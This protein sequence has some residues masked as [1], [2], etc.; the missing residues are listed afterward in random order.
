MDRLRPRE[1]KVVPGFT[2]AEIERMDKLYKESGNQSLDREFYRRVARNFNSSKGRAGKPLVKW[3]E[4]ESWFQKR[5]RDCL[6]RDASSPNPPKKLSVSPEVCPAKKAHSDS[7]IDKDASIDG[8]NVP[9]LSELEFEA[10]SS[11]DGAW[12]DVDTF[13]GHRCLG[14]GETEVHVRYI[15]FGSEEDE[16]VNVKKNVRE[17]SIALEHWECQKVK[18]GDLV[19]CFQEKSDQARYYDAHVLEIQRRLHDIRGCRCLF[20]IRYDHDSSEEKVHLRRLCCR[21]KYEGTF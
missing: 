5:Q 19:L 13:I 12:Y 16:W 9:D 2:E 15:G 14:S 3:I 17:R 11:E 6:P 7:Q 1:R 20:L 4:I 18:V 10:R 8:Q 21:P